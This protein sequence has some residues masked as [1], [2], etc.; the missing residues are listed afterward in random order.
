MSEA[1]PV[2]PV[3]DQSLTAFRSRARAFLESSVPLLSEVEAQGGDADQS[4]AVARE[5]LVQARMAE[6]GFTGLTQP[7]DL[8]GQGLGEA[9]QLVWQQEA[10][11]YAIPRSLYGVSHGM[12]GPII[13]LL[14][15]P[16]QKQKYLPGLWRGET[17]FAQLFS[18][19]G[20]GSDVAGLQAAAARTDGGWRISGQKVW[21]TKAQY[22]DFG[23]LLAR[24]SP[25]L[26]KHDGITMFILDLRAPGVDVRPL[27]V[28]T[29]EYPFNEVFLDD[30][31]VA[32]GDVLGEVGQG[33]AAAIAMLRFERISI[34]TKNTRTVGPHEFGNLV[35]AARRAGLDSR[36][37]TRAA[38]AEAYVL[39]SGADLLATRM[40][41]EADAGLE[42][43]ARGSIAKLAGAMRNLRL[44]EILSDIEGM[45]LVAW[46]EAD[47][48]AP[49]LTRYFLEGPAAWTAGGTMEIQKNIIAERVLG[50]EK[51]HSADRGV[52]FRDIRRGA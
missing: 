12:C 5:R 4:A 27:R 47:A 22:C 10:A 36:P 16:D 26:P 7:R 13:N 41:E 14:G 29:G 31:F 32:D 3:E 8:G 43:G 35:H 34:G 6:A 37:A 52:A 33:W 44:T 11:D 28:A 42:L 18:E 17:V 23:I 39:Q 48:Q 40:R 46:D 49:A 50:L 45:A 1:E 19:P 9:E 51:D 15:T 30:V 21:T 24:T 38:L 25:E 2:R 20:A